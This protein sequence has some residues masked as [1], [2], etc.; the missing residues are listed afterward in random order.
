MTNTLRRLE[1]RRLVEVRP[2]PRD[3]RAK[4]V[5]I[6]RKGLRARDEA[7]AALAPAMAGLEARFAARRFGDALP[8]LRQVRTHLDAARDASGGGAGP[9]DEPK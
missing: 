3:G 2:D 7:I 8:F 6:T 5:R 4:R 9:G 1:A